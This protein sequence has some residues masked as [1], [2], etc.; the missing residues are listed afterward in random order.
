[1]S[2]L[3][4]NLLRVFDAIFELRSVTLTAERL[5][6]TQSAISHALGRLRQA[7]GDPL[8]IRHPGGLQPTA[9]AMEIAPGIRE[10]LAQ[11]Q[12]A[13]APTPF[14]PATARRRFRITA[15]GYFCAVL[16]PEL[17]ARALG[18]QAKHLLRAEQPQQAEPLLREAVGLARKHELR[19]V[20]A[21]LLSL[22]N[23]QRAALDQ[24]DAAAELW[25]EAQRLFARLGMPQAKMQPNWLADP[26]KPTN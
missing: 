3:D 24:P 23:E 12:E 18:A 8:F 19:R 1:M 10:G 16:V 14:D 20:L 15:G 5:N 22:Q 7:F 13:L 21:D 2:N 6:L 11:L 9:R 4:L 25:N 26:A 17:I